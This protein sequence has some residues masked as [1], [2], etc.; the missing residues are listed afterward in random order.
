MDTEQA[1]RVLNDAL[2]SPAADPALA[3]AWSALRAGMRAGHTPLEW[4]RLT[5]SEAA[6]RAGKASTAWAA[7]VNQGY[8][9]PHDGRDLIGRKFWL[10]DTVDRYVRYGYRKGW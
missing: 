6:Q 5:S 9:P 2:T 1:W 8:A 7:A 10:A 3:G 4:Q